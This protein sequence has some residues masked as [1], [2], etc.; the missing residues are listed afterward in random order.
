VD[1]RKDNMKRKIASIVLA[2]IGLT[3]LTASAANAAAAGYSNFAFY[4]GSA[5]FNM[6]IS[7]AGNNMINLSG[8]RVSRSMPWWQGQV[9]D[10][11]A[12]G[13]LQIPNGYAYY[14]YSGYHSGCQYGLAFMDLPGATASYPSGTN[15]SAWW[16]DTN[17]NGTFKKIGDYNN[18]NCYSGC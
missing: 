15:T 12:A 8:Y 16:I 4:G 13:I 3:G 17:T 5:A 14:N 10:Y 6:Y 9:C 2:F 18:L 11:Q 7:N 1:H